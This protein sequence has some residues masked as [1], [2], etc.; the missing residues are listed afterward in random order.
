MKKEEF[1][2]HTFGYILAISFIIIIVSAAVVYVDDSLVFYYLGFI[3]FY[4]V[5]AFVLYVVINEI[6]SGVLQTRAIPL[7]ILWIMAIVISVFS[8]M[9][10]IAHRCGLT[11]EW[12]QHRA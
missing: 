12:L 7:Y 6:A 10:D 3:A 9:A 1:D 11:I 4:S 8:A 5:L 2:Y